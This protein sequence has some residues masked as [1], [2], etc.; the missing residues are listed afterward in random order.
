MTTEA[1]GKTLVV[2][3]TYNEAGNIGPLLE[4]LTSEVP[5]VD[6]LIVDDNSPDGTGNLV[7]KFSAKVP[8]VHLLSRQQKEGLAFAYRAGFKWGIERGYGAFIQMDA[9]FS[10]DP[11]D[12]KRI[13][14]ELQS[15]D[16]VIASRYVPGGQTS[17]WGWHRKVISR[18]GNVY[19]KTILGVSPQDMTGGFN[20]WTKKTLE[21]I[22]YQT[23]T[24]RGYAYQVEMKYRALKA[25]FVP[26]EFP[27]HFRNRTVGTSKMSSSIVFEAAYRVLKLRRG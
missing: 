1:A 16:V 18:G 3:P 9:D 26:F 14:H 13:A 4:R 20:G 23:V 15:H 6:I 21:A 8:Q 24:S 10:H 5:E 11:Q 19:A 12:T 17:G 22:D 25:G 27:I 7:R 2:I